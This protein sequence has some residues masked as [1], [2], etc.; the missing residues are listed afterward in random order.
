MAERRVYVDHFTVLILPFYFAGP[1]SFRSHSEAGLFCILPLRDSYSAVQQNNVHCFFRSIT[2]QYFNLYSRSSS[3]RCS[4]VKYKA[5]VA[6][7]T[8]VYK[9]WSSASAFFLSVISRMARCDKFPLPSFR[10]Q[11]D[12]PQGPLCRLYKHAIISVPDPILLDLACAK[13][14]TRFPTWN[15]RVF[16][17]SVLQ[18]ST[19]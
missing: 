1:V 18:R 7:L 19:L 10:R 11:A 12:L 8:W 3:T 14:S 6:R 2:V 5:S 4:S 9:R 13:N 17:L 16:S 15:S